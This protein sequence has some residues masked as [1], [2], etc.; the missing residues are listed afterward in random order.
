MKEGGKKRK[1]ITILNKI[2]KV[3]LLLEKSAKQKALNCKEFSLA[4]PS[5]PWQVGNAPFEHKTLPLLA[6]HGEAGK[7]W[8]GRTGE[9]WC[10]LAV[11]QPF[12]IYKS[13]K[14][15]ECM[16]MWEKDELHRGRLVWELHCWEWNSSLS[17]MEL[18]L[19]TSLNCDI[20]SVH[21][22]DAEGK[23]FQWIPWKY[24][25]ARACVSSFHVNQCVT[26]TSGEDIM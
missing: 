26:Q 20:H 14:E 1:K 7:S 16:H 19:F 11:Q 6:A 5:P 24:R 2:C 10:F 17:Q 21:L 18:S 22:A 23:S 9:V 8:S 4:P 12:S 13:M 25:S 3:R 15:T